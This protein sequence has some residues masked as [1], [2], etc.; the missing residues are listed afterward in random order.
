M[1]SISEIVTNLQSL[2]CRWFTVEN[3]RMMGIPKDQIENVFNLR[4]DWDSPSRL[5]PLAV[6][7]SNGFG[8]TE[9][10][11]CFV[12]NRPFYSIG[13][14]R[15]LLLTAFGKEVSGLPENLQK[16]LV[17]SFDPN[18][19]WA[20]VEKQESPQKPQKVLKGRKKKACKPLE[21]IDFLFPEL[22]D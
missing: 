1:P 10:Y 3:K 16:L 11:D 7:S 14:N 22:L 15:W 20:Q 19:S 2:G 9:F 12:L 4:I 18:F 21:N 8:L 6:S 13:E 17:A 5:R